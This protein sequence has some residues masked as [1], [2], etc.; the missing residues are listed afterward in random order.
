ME[1]NGFQLEMGFAGGKKGRG[2][3][4]T[5]GINNNTDITVGI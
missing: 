2:L 1:I 4:P 3:A 5:L